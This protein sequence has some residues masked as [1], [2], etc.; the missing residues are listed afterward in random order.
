MKVSLQFR[1]NL[2]LDDHLRY[3]IRYRGNSQWPDTPIRFFDLYSHNRRRLIAARRHSVPKLVKVVVE[4]L[5]EIS[6]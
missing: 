3:P 1:L 5:L 2:N 4:I 6:Q